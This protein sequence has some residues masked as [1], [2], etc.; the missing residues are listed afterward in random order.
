MPRINNIATD[1]VISKNDKLLGS[2]HGGSTRNYV[3]QDITQFIAETNIISPA[4]SFSF[5]YPK[6]PNVLVKGDAK[7][8]FSSGSDFS[9]ATAIKMSKYNY[10]EDDIDVSASFEL[11]NSKDI[12]IYEVTNK[13]NYGLYRASHATVDSNNSNFYNLFIDYKDKGNGA[14]SNE[15]VYAIALY[16]GGDINYTHHQNNDSATWTVNHNLNKFPSVSIKFSSSDTVYE[17][18]GAFAGV[19]YID[20]NNL[21]INL[22]AAESGYAYLN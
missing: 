18:V 4:G 8:T 20:K 16:G 2:D 14:I 9:K 10:G 15:K 12:I 11:L 6:D 5:R 22:A 19:K 3:I 21:T 13:A 17:N 7:F 1:K